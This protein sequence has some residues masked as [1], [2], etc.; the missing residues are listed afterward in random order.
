MPSLVDFFSL[1]RWHWSLNSETDSQTKMK[2]GTELLRFWKKFQPASTTWQLRRD[3]RRPRA[4][5]LSMLSTPNYTFNQQVGVLYFLPIKARSRHQT[6]PWFCLMKS[7]KVIVKTEAWVL[8]RF[9]RQSRSNKAKLW[10]RPRWGNTAASCG[11]YVSSPLTL[12]SSNKNPTLKPKR[13]IKEILL[14]TFIAERV[15]NTREWWQYPNN[16]MKSTL[17]AESQQCLI[18]EKCRIMPL[19]SPSPR[20][21]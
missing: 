13:T 20:R 19:I 14:A 5:L 21:S 11:T 4:S 6:K 17:D 7:V 2:S 8:R 18:I 3:E 9:S 16:I 1:P 12:E 15:L 10:I